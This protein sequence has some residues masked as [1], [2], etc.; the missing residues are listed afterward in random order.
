MDFEQPA[1][2]WNS[3]FKSYFSISVSAIHQ[4]DFVFAENFSGESTT[5]NLMMKSDLAT[6]GDGTVL[7][8]IL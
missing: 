3:Y 4:P 5:L 6:S 7:N 1:A 8:L 2:C